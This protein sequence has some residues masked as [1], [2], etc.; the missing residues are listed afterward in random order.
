VLQ[1]IFFALS[2]PPCPLSFFLC[3]R[4][5]KCDNDLTYKNSTFF[6]ALKA[7]LLFL[8]SKF[9]IVF[10]YAQ[11]SLSRFVERKEK[12]IKIFITTHLPV[13]S[14]KAPSF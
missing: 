2:L 14:I 7:K 6:F 13:I 1:F 8:S 11:K 3:S 5:E 9:V 4:R 10:F 12:D